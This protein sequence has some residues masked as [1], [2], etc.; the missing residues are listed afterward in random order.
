MFD[1]ICPACGGAL[2]RSFGVLDCEDSLCGFSI[3]QETYEEMYG[4]G[5]DW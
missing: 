4:E 1:H 5:E 3:D 2:E